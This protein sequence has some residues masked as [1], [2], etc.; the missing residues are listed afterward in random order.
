MQVAQATASPPHDSLA[1]SPSSQVPSSVRH[2]TKSNGWLENIKSFFARHRRQ[3]PQSLTPY[4]MDKDPHG[5]VLI[6]NNINFQQHK[7]REG[8]EFDGEALAKIFTKLRYQLYRGKIHQDCCLAEMKGL[9]QSVAQVDHTQYDSFICC[10]LSHGKLNAVYSTDEGL[11]SMEEIRKPIIDCAS[12][13]GKPKM[14][15]LQACWGKNFPE[16]H[17]IQTDGDRDKQ[18]FL[19]HDNDIFFGFSTTPDT[20]ACRFTD[21]GSWYVIELV[22]ALEQNHKN[23]DFVS[24]VTAAHC[25]VATN[26]E[27]IFGPN[28]MYKQSP[29]LVSTLTRPVYF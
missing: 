25:E 13:V 26:P 17:F 8:S 5:L 20:R 23:F 15:F 22:K 14:F 3:L 16:G 11:M 1:F 19:P 21:I 18:I 27:Y 4:K 6:I 2:S 24:M 29:Q 7:Q 12:L 10:I 28:N 9:L